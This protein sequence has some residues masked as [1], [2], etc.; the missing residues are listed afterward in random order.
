MTHRFSKLPDDGDPW[1]PNN[2]LTPEQKK[3][4]S[5][6]LEF[7]KC[8]IGDCRAGFPNLIKSF[9][10]LND[11]KRMLYSHQFKYSRK[12]VSVHSGFIPSIRENT[13]S[14]AQV[15]K[16]CSRMNPSKERLLEI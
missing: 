7:V 15:L 9:Q 13:V 16:K 12:E 14:V 5:W 4:I 3:N 2:L 10:S 6:N 8:V 1:A 11:V